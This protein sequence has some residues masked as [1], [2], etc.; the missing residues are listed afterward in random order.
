MST[1]KQSINEKLKTAMKEKNAEMLNV[2]RG[3]ISK[4]TE[5]E[6]ANSNKELTDDEVIKVIEKLAKQ[7]EE[8][9]SLFKKG[10]RDD[11]VTAEEFQLNVLKEYLPQ[12]MDEAATRKAVDE[13]IQAGATNIGM[14][15][16]ELAKYGN[17]ID[18]KL[19]SQI[20]NELIAK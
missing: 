19:A 6:K 20:A 11:L 1:L 15:M 13:A 16:K 3:V 10:N 8:S 2:L 5:A 4:V 18:K 7:R 12:K 9:I 14:L 17:L